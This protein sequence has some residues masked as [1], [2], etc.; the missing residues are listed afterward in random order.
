MRGRLVRFEVPLPLER[1]P[2]VGLGAHELAVAGVA[3]GVA[4][5]VGRLVEALVADGAHVFPGEIMN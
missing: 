3:H 4:R 5:E 2:A 1:L